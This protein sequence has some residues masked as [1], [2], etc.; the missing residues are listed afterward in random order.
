VPS[1]SI[2]EYNAVEKLTYAQQAQVPSPARVPH[3]DQLCEKKDEKMKR[4]GE[5]KKQ[6]FVPT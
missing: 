6:K 2:M 4:E 3:R 1:A 5:L